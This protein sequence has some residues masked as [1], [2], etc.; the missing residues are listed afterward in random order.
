MWRRDEELRIESA[1][2]AERFTE[3]VG[4]ANTLTD[5]GRADPSFRYR[6]VRGRC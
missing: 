2:N 4:V 5:A 6:G 1:V 3:G